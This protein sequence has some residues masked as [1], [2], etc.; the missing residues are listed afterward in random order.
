MGI[1]FILLLNV[2]CSDTPF[3]VFWLTT[4]KII[5]PEKFT[6]NRYSLLSN[7]KHI[8]LQINTKK[9]QYNLWRKHAI[10]EGNDYYKHETQFH[11]KNSKSAHIP[12][13]ISVKNNIPDILVE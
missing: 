5:E 11:K 6:G 7:S 9:K 3:G 13:V 8:G 1:W 12:F 2:V 10:C 4:L